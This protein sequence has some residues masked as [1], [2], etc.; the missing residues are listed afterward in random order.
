MIISPSVLHKQIQQQHDSKEL[1]ML[2]D[3][4]INILQV[5]SGVL[6]KIKQKDDE[7]E[8]DNDDIRYNVILYTELI[9]ELVISL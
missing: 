7:T 9:S 4:V 8:N 3:L 2:N 5:L 6:Y 1:G